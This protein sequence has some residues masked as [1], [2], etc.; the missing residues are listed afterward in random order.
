MITVS[1]VYPQHAGARF[2]FDYYMQ[3]H[4]PLVQQLL[5]GALKGVQVER[6]LS[7]AEPG[8]APGYAA[9]AQLVFESA[10]AF[11]RAFGPVAARI[12]DDIPNYTDIRPVIQLN[13]LLLQ[14]ARQAGVS[15]WYAG[16]Q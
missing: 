13:E 6:G 16:A 3:K 5:R 10:E 15:G 4:M 1:V 7:G 8:S 14:E 9:Q 2:D 11:Q 12:M